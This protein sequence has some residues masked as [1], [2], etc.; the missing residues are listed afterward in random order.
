MIFRGAA[1]SLALAQV[2]LHE[3]MDYVDQIRSQLIM[4]EKATVNVVN[5]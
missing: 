5:I 4:H 2:S 1:V 3:I